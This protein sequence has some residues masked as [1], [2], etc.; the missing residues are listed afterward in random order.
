[1]PA[2]SSSGPTYS[3]WARYADSVTSQNTMRSRA[4]FWSVAA[5]RARFNIQNFAEHSQMNIRQ[6]ER[7]CQEELGRTP[8]EW[9]SEQRMIAAR[10]L[11]LELDSIKTVALE[12]GYKYPSHFCRQFKQ[13]YGLTP[14]QYLLR[15]RD[16]N[17]N[18]ALV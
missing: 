9:L 8:E 13:F 10:L 4:Q 12:L 5:R 6:I 7:R 17:A 15:Q 11:L 1:M 2:I 14:S 18:V 16:I 3:A